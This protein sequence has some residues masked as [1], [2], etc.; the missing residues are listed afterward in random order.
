MF[1]SSCSLTEVHLRALLALG[2]LS[3]DQSPPEP[4]IPRLR[5]RAQLGKAVFDKTKCLKGDL[6]IFCSYRLS[7]S[8]LGYLARHYWHFW[9]ALAAL[10]LGVDSTS[11]HRPSEFIL[12]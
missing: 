7:R 5:R 8:R 6:Y 12:A 10:N 3:S 4:C 11:I 9:A 2:L 1:T